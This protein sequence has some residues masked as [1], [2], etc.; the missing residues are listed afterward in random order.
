MPQTSGAGAGP[1]PGKGKETRKD[2]GQG[3]KT[4][5]QTN[6]DH[7]TGKRGKAKGLQTRKDTG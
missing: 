2:F 6:D 5:H 4:H 1:S 3:E 7:G